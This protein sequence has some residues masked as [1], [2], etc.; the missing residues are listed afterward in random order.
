[1][2][3]LADRHVDGDAGAVPSGSGAVIGARDTGA[4]AAVERRADFGAH[5]EAE[6][7]RLVGQ[8]FA[9]TL[10]P[11]EAHDVVQDAYSRAWREWDEIGGSADPAAWVRRVAVRSTVR[12]WKRVLGR[13]GTSRARSIGEGADP[14]TA[15]LL[16]ALAELPAEERRAVVLFHM[17]GASRAEIAA[18]EQ[19]SPSTVQARLTRAHHVVVEGMAEIPAP[20]PG[21]AGGSADDAAGVRGEGEGEQR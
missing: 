17:A 8:L 16:T 18:I 11:R 21:V 2:R 6:Y 13:R 12:S 3:A 4:A 1:M 10:D 20:P 7:P 14:R 19:T 5:F 9:I 15:A